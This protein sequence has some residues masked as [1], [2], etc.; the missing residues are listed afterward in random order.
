MKMPPLIALQYFCLAAELGSL[1][2]CADA[3]NVTEGAVSRQIKSLSQFYAKA[4]FEKSG[5]G[6]VLTEHGRTLAAGAQPAFTRI[7]QV[8]NQLLS[9]HSD[10]TLGVTTSFAIRWLLPKLPDFER[11]FPDYRVKLQATSNETALRG[12]HFD[13]QISYYLEGCEPATLR[14]HKLQDE[15]LLAVC[16]PNY[17]A[18]GQ[19]LDIDALSAS[20]L[21]LNER[22]GRDWRLWAQKLKIA[23]IDPAIESALSFEQDDVAIQA[24]VAG[25]GVALANV[26]YIEREMSLGSL[27]PATEIAPLVV[28]AHYITAASA[29]AHTRETR[30]VLQ[31]LRAQVS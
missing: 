25:H 30:S 2:A 27:V 10:I 16:S 9:A 8:S 12:E 14:P 11:Q 18:R 3:F 31:W 19:R 17:L 29:R 21:L 22:T 6:L 7:H 13:V 24:A 26:A 4:L 23:S 28:G 5:R 15:W 1:K 20:R